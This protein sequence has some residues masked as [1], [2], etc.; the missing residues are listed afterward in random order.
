MSE[1][2]LEGLSVRIDFGKCRGFKAEMG[3]VGQPERP[4]YYRITVHDNLG[5]EE[6][7]EALAHE[8]VHVKQYATG[9]MRDYLSDPDF[10]RWENEPHEFVDDDSEG[11][12]FAPWEVEARGM[13][14]G[15]SKVF[16]AS[17]P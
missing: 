1:T 16:L 3:W 9:K 13:E 5:K 11:Y 17:L 6:T 12:W 7:L 4:K 10:V 8:M 15:L 14:K 2:L